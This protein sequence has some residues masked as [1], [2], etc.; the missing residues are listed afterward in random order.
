[1]QQNATALDHVRF[2]NTIAVEN[3]NGSIL[4]LAGADDQI[5]PSCTLSQIAS[6]RLASSGH[7]AKYH[8]SYVCYPDTGHNVEQPGSPTS[9][10][11]EA[12]V[13]IDG[14]WLLFGGT[15][16]GI[17]HTARDSDTRIRKFLAENL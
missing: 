12:Y 4:L 16:A 8:D 5:W 9:N 11:T 14:G 3:T 17:A 15:P 2:D 1:M 10:A 7:S 13:A 6:D